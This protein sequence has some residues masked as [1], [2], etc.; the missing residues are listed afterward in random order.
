VGVQRRPRPRRPV[1]WAVLAEGV[2]RPPHTPVAPAGVE[3]A[4][5][6]G[7]RPGGG[8]STCFVTEPIT[9]TSCG[10]V[11][12]LVGKGSTIEFSNNAVTCCHLPQCGGWCMGTFVPRRRHDAS[13]PHGAGLWSY[14]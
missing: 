6:E 11:G 13:C 9:P 1:S 12:E 5:P 14:A 7:H 8:T 2:L 10:E 4:R 3:P